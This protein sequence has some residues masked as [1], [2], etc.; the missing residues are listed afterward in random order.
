VIAFLYSNFSTRPWINRSLGINYFFNC[1]IN[2]LQPCLLFFAI[3]IE[4]IHSEEGKKIL[5]VSK[6]SSDAIFEMVK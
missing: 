2:G 5:K 3:L 4:K 6:N 1:S